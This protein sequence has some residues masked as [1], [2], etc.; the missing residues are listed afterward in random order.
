L[1]YFILVLDNDQ[2]ERQGSE[3]EQ[4]YFN[5][6]QNGKSGDKGDMNSD[7]QRPKNAHENSN[8]CQTGDNSFDDS[9][10][11]PLIE[12]VGIKETKTAIS[13]S[14]TK[15]R[16]RK[17]LPSEP[18]KSL[19][20]EIRDK[21]TITKVDTKVTSKRNEVPEEI[22]QENKTGKK[23]GYKKLL[24]ILESWDTPKPILD[25]VTGIWLASNFRHIL[26]C[27]MFHFTTYREQNPIVCF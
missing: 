1:I 10:D 12:H 7:E 11:R 22:S 19:N 20:L 15:R 14:K 6:D 24:K 9:S 16:T 2:F 13:S 3:G 27:S 25:I 26:N 21:D 17:C 23:K 4:D 18:K 5:L 8:L